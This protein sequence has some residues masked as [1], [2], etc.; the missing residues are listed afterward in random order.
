MAIISLSEAKEHLRVDQ[1]NEDTLIQIYIN[2]ADEYI[3]NYLN[4]ASYPKNNAIKA[5]ALLVV[6]GLYE[7]REQYGEAEIKENPAVKNLLYP[8]RVRLGL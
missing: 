8:Y 4:S 6:G 2:A 1:N 7:N 3:A 5:A